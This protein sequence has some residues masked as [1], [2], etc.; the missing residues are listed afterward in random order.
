MMNEVKN[1]FFS[2]FDAYIVNEEFVL[3]KDNLIGL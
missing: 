2:P 3:V 1:V